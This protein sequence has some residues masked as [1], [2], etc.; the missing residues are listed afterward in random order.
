MIESYEYNSVKD[1]SQSQDSTGGFWGRVG[2]DEQAEQDEALV[3]PTPKE[4]GS[5]LHILSKSKNSERG[6]NWERSMELLRDAQEKEFQISELSFQRGMLGHYHVLC[7][8]FLAAGIAWV[9]GRWMS[10]LGC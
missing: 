5:M 10:M 1:K 6:S 3:A 8:F 4:Y 7:F 2:S 9:D